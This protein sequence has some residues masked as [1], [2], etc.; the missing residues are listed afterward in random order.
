MGNINQIG[1][2]NDTF[3]MVVSEFRCIMRNPHFIK[4]LVSL[5]IMGRERERERKRLVTGNALATFTCIPLALTA[6][7]GRRCF[8]KN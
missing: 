6:I 8:K 3:R 7:E 2:K 1:G 4:R 5:Y